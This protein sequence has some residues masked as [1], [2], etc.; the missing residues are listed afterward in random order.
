MKKSPKHKYVQFILIC[1][2]KLRCLIWGVIVKTVLVR[3]VVH[4]VW[5]VKYTVKN[6]SQ[7]IAEKQDSILDKHL[8]VDNKNY[9]FFLLLIQ[10]NFFLNENPSPKSGRV[11]DQD[12]KR[13]CYTR[14]RT[15]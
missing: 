3:C 2:I 15:E 4:K 9:R 8:K 12:D 6:D 13:F 10:G 5:K 7:S 11:N 14:D 1:R